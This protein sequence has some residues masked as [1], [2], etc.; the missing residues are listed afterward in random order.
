MVIL[1]NRQLLWVDVGVYCFYY[2]HIAL[3]VDVS[4]D[5]YLIKLVI[6]D[7]GLFVVGPVDQVVVGELV[8]NCR[9]EL[10]LII[11]EKK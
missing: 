10:D 8:N 6:N 3:I 4:H 2:D 5:V 7:N 1:V 11:L 9:N